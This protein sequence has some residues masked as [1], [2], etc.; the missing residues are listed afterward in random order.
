MV[1]K[2]YKKTLDIVE[3]RRFEFLLLATVVL[4]V[5][6]AISGTGLISDILFVLS[7]SFLFIHTKV[8]PIDY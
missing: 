2:H 3:Q 7:L 6:P 8:Q 5:L 4:L 1:K